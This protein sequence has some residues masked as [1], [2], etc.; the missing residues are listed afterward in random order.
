MGYYAQPFAVDLGK[1]RQILGS[2]ISHYSKPEIDHLLTMLEKIQLSEKDME[3]DEGEVLQDL[4]MA[5][6]NCLRTCRE[7]GVEWVS[8]IH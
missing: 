7:K 2:G 3:S 1:I 4:I 8:F 6:T 5:F